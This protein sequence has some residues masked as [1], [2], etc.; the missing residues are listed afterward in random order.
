MRKMLNRSKILVLLLA[1]VSVL[2]ACRKPGST[3]SASGDQPANQTPTAQASPLSEFETKLQYV[4][5]GS[6]TYVWVF[7]R[8]DGKPFTKE[9]GDYLRT[10]APQVV[11]WVGMDDKTKYIA[12]TNFDLEKGN[13]ELLKKRFV[14]EDYSAR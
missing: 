6:F 13:M 11:Y 10:N 14:V 1:V 2:S 4:K 3:P 8:K 12:G 7:S 9:D 5:N